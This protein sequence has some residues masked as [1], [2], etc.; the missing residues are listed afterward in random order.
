M[1]TELQ[2]KLAQIDW[3]A[4]ASDS[5]SEDAGFSEIQVNCKLMTAWL[6]E[7]CDMYE[8][9]Y[10]LSFLKEAHVSMNDY[11]TSMSV[12]LYKLSAASMRTILES[13]LYYSYFKDHTKEF[14]TLIN[15]SSYYLSRTEVLEY[16]YKHTRNFKEGSKELNLIASMD[17][18]YS[19]VSAIIHGQIPGVWQPNLTLNSRSHCQKTFNC[20]VKQFKT[21]VKIINQ[22]LIIHLTEE[23]WKSINFRSREVFLKGLKPKTKLVIKRT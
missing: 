21:L 10:A 18:F 14:H 13:I 9:N 12:A 4:I 6:N 15:D 17:S 11:C 2:T 3:G 8:G 20:S 5:L 19:E 16:H 1:T 7:L 22:F 23:E